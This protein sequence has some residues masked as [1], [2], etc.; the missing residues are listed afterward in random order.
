MGLLAR[1]SAMLAALPLLMGYILGIA[2]TP[3]A[4][5]KMIGQRICFLRRQQSACLLVDKLAGAVMANSGRWKLA[6]GFLS[7]RLLGAAG[8]RLRICLERA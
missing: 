4:D 7:G 6:W 2:E 8:L 3:I 1:Y 5:E